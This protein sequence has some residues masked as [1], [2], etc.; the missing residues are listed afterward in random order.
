MQSNACRALN[1]SFVGVQL[2]V[3]DSAGNEST[4]SF[5]LSVPEFKVIDSSNLNSVLSYSTLIQNFAQ[6]LRDIAAVLEVS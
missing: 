4:K 6:Q 5:E 3:A 1:F 2:R